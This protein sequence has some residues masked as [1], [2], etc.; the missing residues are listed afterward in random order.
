MSDQP[1]N[2]GHRFKKGQ[3]GNPSGKS[4]TKWLTD[5]LRMELAQNPQKARNIARKVIKMAE[6]GDL[7][8]TKLVFDRLEGR[9]TQ[10]IEIDA[11]VTS[12]TPDQR[13]QRLLELQAKV[14]G[15]TLVTL[16]SPSDGDD[17][18]GRRH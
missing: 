15:E 17:D 2:V 12:M 8:A 5:A 11:T 1:K 4:K 7:E 6:D 14:I 13:R 16:P 3:S 9:P 18:D 10:A